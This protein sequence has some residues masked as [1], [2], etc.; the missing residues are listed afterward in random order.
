MEI[1][2]NDFSYDNPR[3][4]EEDFLVE[5]K[6][7]IGDLC[8]DFKI[9]ETDVGRAADIPVFLINISIGASILSG[10]TIIVDNAIKFKKWLN[11][12]KNKYKGIRI[13]EE[14]ATL[15]IFQEILDKVKVIE[16]IEEICKTIIP[17]DPP[18]RKNK[19]HKL[20]DQPDAFY[21]QSYKVNINKIYTTIVKSDSC[22]DLFHKTEIPEWY[23]F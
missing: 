16:S 11:K 14:C 3:I 7:D 2:I 1:L 10:I 12:N 20:D 6:K 8:D 4:T 23:N 22:I 18:F 13:C 21:I 19:T 15:L 9:I 17:V 5:L